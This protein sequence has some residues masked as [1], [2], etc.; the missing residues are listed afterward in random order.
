MPKITFEALPNL[1]ALTVNTDAG[2]KRL[3]EEL[4]SVVNSLSLKLVGMYSR[5]YQRLVEDIARMIMIRDSKKGYGRI[6]NLYDYV[7][8]QLQSLF[9]D[10]KSVASA[11]VP[12][13]ESHNAASPSKGIDIQLAKKIALAFFKSSDNA[14]QEARKLSTREQKS[15]LESIVKYFASNNGELVRQLA[16]GAG[17]SFLSLPSS[18]S[19]AVLSASVQLVL[20]GVNASVYNPIADFIHMDGEVDM[21]RESGHRYGRPASEQDVS[22]LVAS[23]CADLSAAPDQQVDQQVALS[24]CG[25]VYFD[26]IP[27]VRPELLAE[28]SRAIQKK[29]NMGLLTEYDIISNMGQQLARATSFAL[30]MRTE[31]ELHQMGIVSK[32]APM[33]KWSNV[34]ALAFHRS[35][36]RDEVL[37]G[38]VRV[39]DGRV[40]PRMRAFVILLMNSSGIAVGGAANQQV[41]L[42]PIKHGLQSIQLKATVTVLAGG[43]GASMGE[44]AMP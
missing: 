37:A 42:E 21:F 13:Y 9:K 18:A 38:A 24:G 30:K 31:D 39:A 16:H 28:A 40:A 35:A 25:T 4:K 2:T 32:T 8:E 5:E 36:L 23:F 11:F 14:P 7:L 19:Q 41:T 10:E 6:F 27:V 1:S 3:R 15:Q 33:L 22:S 12:S 29:P 44:D 17:K 26:G 20:Q 34:N 43:A